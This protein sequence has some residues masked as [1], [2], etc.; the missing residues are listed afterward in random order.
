M[1]KENKTALANVPKYHKIQTLYKRGDDGQLLEGEWSRPYLEYLQNNEWVF[2]E[3][4][5]G[6]NIRVHWDQ[7]DQKVSFG[8][9]TDRAQIYAPLVQKLIEMFP[10][11]N[12]QEAFPLGEDIITLFGEGYGSRIQAGGGNYRSD[13]SFVLFDIL[14]G[15]WW[16]RRPDV[17]AIAEKLGLDVVPI[18]GHGTLHQAV[19]T[20]RNGLTSTWGEFRAEGLVARPAVELKARSGERVICK[21]KHRDFRHGNES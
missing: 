1:S 17:E 12:L 10:A 14:I 2:T 13:V 7:K 16:L 3:K 9:R 15:H 5:D 6:T 18:I 8:G 4:V 21:I 19:E 11:K 20:V